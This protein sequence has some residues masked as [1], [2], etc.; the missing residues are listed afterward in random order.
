MKRVLLIEDDEDLR[1]CYGEVLKFG[2]YDVIMAADG[3]QGMGLLQ[4][5]AIDLVITDLF[6][7]GKD[8]VETI[9]AIRL[10]HPGFKII[11]I[12]GGG[13]I[14]KPEYLKPM[15]T[16]LGVNRFLMKP[17]AGDLLLAAVRSVLDGAEPPPES[18]AA[19]ASQGPE[20][21]GR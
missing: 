16:S 12:S 9:M 17:I 2:G 19:A 3:R 7:P 15:V 20:N 14:V 8:G 21:A 1:Y 13:Q 5:Q 6:M 4:E 18:R 11:A 10:L